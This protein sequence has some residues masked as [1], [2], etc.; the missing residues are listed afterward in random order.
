MKIRTFVARQIKALSINLIAVCL[1]VLTT[2]GAYAYQQNFVVKNAFLYQAIIVALESNVGGEGQIQKMTLTNSTRLCSQRADGSW[3]VLPGGICNLTTVNNI[4]A[5]W[6]MC[7]DSIQALFQGAPQIN[8]SGSSLNCWDGKHTRIEVS[9]A[10]PGT[11]LDISVIPSGNNAGVFCNDPQWGGCSYNNADK[12]VNVVSM[13]G[14]IWCSQ[15]KPS[16]PEAAQCNGTIKNQ[17]Y[18][19]GLETV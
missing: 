7:A 16:Q 18:C 1:S 10:S 8:A 9:E 11:N 19:S 4:H 13:G 14:N 2:G 5:G 15:L 12:T 6:R 3:Y 17:S